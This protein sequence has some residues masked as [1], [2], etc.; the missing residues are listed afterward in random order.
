MTAAVDN[1]TQFAICCSTHKKRNM[2]ERERQTE[3]KV[4]LLG[5]NYYERE[6]ERKKRRW[7]MLEASNLY[8]KNDMILIRQMKWNFHLIFAVS[9]CWCRPYHTFFPVDSCGSQNEISNES[10]NEENSKNP[11]KLSLRLSL[12]VARRTH[13]FL[14]N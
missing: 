12:P 3:M 4:T 1:K 13:H 8:G 9:R 5:V 10:S 7:K 6:K 11:F 14:P 2:C